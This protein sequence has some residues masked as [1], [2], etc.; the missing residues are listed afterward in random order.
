MLYESFYA[1][2]GDICFDH[3]IDG[4]DA[5]Y[6]RF[7]YGPYL[8][9]FWERTFQLHHLEGRRALHGFHGFSELI[10]LRKQGKMHRV[11]QYRMERFVLCPRQVDIS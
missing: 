6:R 7:D 4:C 10:F 1:P 11:D 9:S 2:F 5:D 8:Q 3:V